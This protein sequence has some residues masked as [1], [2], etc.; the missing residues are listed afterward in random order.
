MT[1]AK[2]D[3]RI[4][5]QIVKEW[6]PVH[7]LSACDETIGMHHALNNLDSHSLKDAA[8][9]YTSINDLDEKELHQATNEAI[10]VARKLGW[11]LASTLTCHI[12]KAPIKG[13]A[14]MDMWVPREL[15][16]YFWEKSEAYKT[17]LEVQQSLLEVLHQAP[18]PTVSELGAPV[19][20]SDYGSYQFQAP[21]F[22]NMSDYEKSLITGKQG[23]EWHPP[24]ISPV[25]VHPYHTL[26]STYCQYDTL[27]SVVLAQ[28]FY[29]S[30]QEQGLYDVYVENR[31]NTLMTYFMENNGVSFRYKFAEK[32]LAPYLVDAYNAKNAATYSIN[33]LFP[34]N[35]DSPKQLQNIL[36]T[37]FGLPVERYTKNKKDRFALGQPSTDKEVLTS[38]IARSKP[39]NPEDLFPP[40]F[41]PEITKER[42]YF[43][44]LEAWHNKLEH[45]TD[46]KLVKLF[47]FCCSIL[48]YKDSHA[49]I[50]QIKNYLF[51]HLFL[52]EEH[53][54]LFQSINPY[55][56]NT[57]RQSHSNPNGANISKGGKQAK[58]VAFLFRNDK[59][60]R[61]LFGPHPGR[62]WYSVDFVQFQLLIFAVMAKDHAMVDAYVKG[63]DLHD[64]TARRLLGYPLDPAHPDFNRL[65]PTSNERT[66]AKALN[67]GFCFGAQEAKLNRIGGVPGFYAILCNTL[68]GVVGFL[69]KMEWQVQSKG[70]VTTLGGYRLYVP[71]ETPYAGSVYAIQGTEAEMMKRAT[72]GVQYYLDTEVNTY[73][74][75]TRRTAS[76]DMFITLPVHDEL[77]FDAKKGVGQ[78]HIGTVC[79]IMADAAASLGVP[80]RVECK[81]IPENWAEGTP[82]EFE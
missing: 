14:V 44:A 26:C 81:Y 2:F 13:F 46:P 80:A 77:V 63:Q 20:D 45:A 39:E 68:P 37:I 35:P 47:S 27:R 62:E 69:D 16:M 40:R 73:K 79:S 76:R 30:L 36:Y 4:L 72:Y 53:S 8:T 59:T 25:D 1:N 64:L 74:Y 3:V 21:H 33:P 71:Q 55:G 82:L 57:G 22:K 52:E 31:L 9:K 6:D 54:T 61:S 17:Y 24:D 23:W 29:K 49:A 60:L 5:D 42:D 15:A 78:Y 7:F 43:K 70:Y 11:K 41:T 66:T 28:M 38:W 19:P 65:I 58:S 12:A 10:T 50:T 18:S 32:E 34:L 75:M 51:N 56:T 67:F 48:Q